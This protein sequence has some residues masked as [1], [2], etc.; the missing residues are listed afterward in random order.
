MSALIDGFLP[1]FLMIALGWGLKASGFLTGDAW[2]PVERL[3][4]FI[5][6]PA[7]LIPAVWRADFAGGSAGPVAL[8]TVGAALVLAG[9]FCL[10]AFARWAWLD[11]GCMM[12]IGL[13]SG[14]IGHS[15]HGTMPRRSICT[16]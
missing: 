15:S 2:K 7:F 3:T 5:F 11:V 9:L 6:Y 12:A 1:V 13:A 4:Y 14:F 8:G 16:A 10:L